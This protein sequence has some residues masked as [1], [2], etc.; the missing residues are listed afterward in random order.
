MGEALSVPICLAHLVVVEKA[1]TDAGRLRAIVAAASP[2]IRRAFLDAVAR[3]SAGVDRA[4]LRRALDRGDVAGA[5]ATIPWEELGARGLRNR[6][7]RELLGI[8][9]SGGDLA[10]KRLSRSLSVDISFD[11]TN[12]RA[13]EW[14]RRNAGALIEE[15]GR[16]S[17]DAV[18]RL[19]VDGFERG[20]TAKR[21]ASLILESGIGLT[22]RH[23]LALERYRASLENDPDVNLSQS[24]VDARVVSRA[25]RMLRTRADTIARTETIA[26]STQGQ[27]RL[28]DQAED[29][30]LIDSTAEVEWVAA[31]DDRTDEDCLGLDGVRRP[32]HGTFPG[33]VSGPPLHPDCRCALSLIPAVVARS[34]RARVA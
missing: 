18:R 16:T 25:D 27:L 8:V 5:L 17:L 30:G 32:L 15:F 12:P 14:A 7:P 31:R 22:E 33:G 9:E 20:V 24:Q 3:A 28:W 19:I 2:R 26:A 6:M 21:T 13:T 10:A 34:G 4:A 29:E 11:V 1:P 23:V